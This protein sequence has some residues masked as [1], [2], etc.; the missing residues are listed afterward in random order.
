LFKVESSFWVGLGIVI[1]AMIGSYWAAGKLP[2][3]VEHI[4]RYYAYGRSVEY[5]NSNAG[6]ASVFSVTRL[7]TAPSLEMWFYAIGMAVCLINFVRFSLRW[8]MISGS[9]LKLFLGI[10]AAA[11][12]VGSMGYTYF[13]VWNSRMLSS[14]AIVYINYFVLL[15]WICCHL[16][17]L[18]KNHFPAKVVAVVGLLVMGFFL[19]KFIVVQDYSGSYTTRDAPMTTVNV[20]V[21]RGIHIYADQREDIEKLLKLTAG[22]GPRDYLV[23]MSE[24]TT[25]GYISHLRNPTYYRLFT[26]EFAPRGEQERAIRT[27]EHYKIR[28]FVARRSQ[29]LKGG[30]PSS[31]LA[32][33]APKI[34]AWLLNK[35]DV[36]P[37]G[38]YFVLLE[39]KNRD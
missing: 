24:A 18:S 1:A 20:P 32:R 36:I 28:Y 26:S 15:A 37:L 19:S 29:F 31:D 13:Y 34:K 33:Y 38:N 22:A 10:T 27:F 14:F 16:S 4:Q 11:F 8:L 23:S 7:V 9:D 39:R 5:I 21:L 6:I 35:Y 30:G 2:S 25:M 3:L 12:G 17:R